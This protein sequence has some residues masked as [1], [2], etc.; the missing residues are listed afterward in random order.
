M[1]SHSFLIVVLA[2]VTLLSFSQL[3]VAA[4][5]PVITPAPGFTRDAPKVR[6]IVDRKSAIPNGDLKARA[7]DRHLEERQN[8]VTSCGYAFVDCGDGSCCSYGE[9][10]S[11]SGTTTKCISAFSGYSVDI[12]SILDSLSS[13][14]SGLP[15]DFDKYLTNIPTNSAGLSAYLASLT[16]MEF[17]A[18]KPTGSA[19]TGAGSRASNG[20][21]LQSSDSSANKSASLSG[22][23]I[24]GIAVGGVIAIAAIAA[25]VAFVL[26]RRNRKNQAAANSVAPPLQPPQMAKPGYPPQTPGLQTPQT[27]YSQVAP[28]YPGIENG[29]FVQQQQKTDSGYYQ[30]PMPGAQEA[31]GDTK[32]QG[33]MPVQGQQ[34]QW[35][36]N[37]PPQNP[38]DVG[39]PALVQQQWQPGQQQQ[40][41]TGQVTAVNPVLASNAPTHVV[42]EMDG[43]VA[44]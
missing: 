31:E 12:D 20:P 36:Q 18:G 41:Y 14:M 2:T 17:A 23:A 25:I 11:K 35:P 42:Y 24:G 3:V 32:H 26:F 8:F 19:A 34:P 28:P 10:C 33:I 1:L 29:A 39:N 16:S 9:V 22:G 7:P 43:G 44:R 21:S 4:P 5:E 15:T 38:H 13:L 30:P 27:A 37:P 40:H 6:S